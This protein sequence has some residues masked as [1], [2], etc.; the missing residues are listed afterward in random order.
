MELQKEIEDNPWRHNF[1]HGPS[2]KGSNPIG[3]M[4]GVLVVRDKSNTLGFLAGFS[5]KMA[6]SNEHKGFVPPVFNIYQE[7]GVFRI[8]EK[9]LIALNTK[10]KDLELES[11]YVRLLKEKEVA[12]NRLIVIV[13]HEKAALKAQKQIRKEKREWAKQELNRE[14]QMELN[15]TLDQQSKTA[16]IEHK[17]RLK[18]WKQKLSEL[19]EKLTPFEKRIKELKAKRAKESA[20]LQNELFASFTFLNKRGKYKS[21]EEIFEQTSFGVPPAG[22]GE[23]AGPRLF[24]YAFQQN[25][26]PICMTEF[27]WG[28][29]PDSELRIHKKHYPACRGKCVPIFQHMLDGIAQEILPFKTKEAR[30][31]EVLYNDDAIIVVNKPPGLLSVPG[32]GPWPSVYSMLKEQYKEESSLI[33]AHRLDMETSGILVVAKSQESYKNLQ[34]QFLKREVRKV[35]EA[36][37][38]CMPKEQQGTINL[39]LKPD[40]LNRPWQMVCFE[41]GKEAITNY[42]VIDGKDPQ[43]IRL[44]LE[45]KTGRTHQLRIHLAHQKGLNSPIV[46]DELYGHVDKRLYLHAREMEFTHPTSGKKMHIK[47]KCPF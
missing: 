38:Q 35:Y 26:E 44:E 17:K 20:Q 8:K 31:L 23:C 1:G 47:T 16:Q 40:I 12:Q 37:I 11:Q 39:P 24:Q 21:L 46:G 14:E 28:K 36:L 22:A 5:G 33:L 27:W 43:R 13:Q 32:I 41:K 18:E 29:A 10:I 6:D 7:Q 34:R 30:P 45:P 19:E 15:E 2:Q 42:K 25:L 3:K 9:E 4:F